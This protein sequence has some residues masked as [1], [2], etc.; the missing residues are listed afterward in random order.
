MTAMADSAPAPKRKV[1]PLLWAGLALMGCAL[2]WCLSYYSQWQGLQF[3]DIK[4]AC[5]NGDT[6]ECT[7][8]Q[9]FIGPSTIPVYSPFAW[10]AGIGLTLV[11][12]YLTRRQRV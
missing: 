6:M 8:F 2:A 9:D 10:Y 11:G 12:L 1:N 3:L 4:L 7:N 5:L